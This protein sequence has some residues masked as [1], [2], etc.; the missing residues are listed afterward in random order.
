MKRNINT[1]DRIIRFI[2]TVAFTILMLNDSKDKMIQILAGFLGFYCLATA[3][4]EYCVIYGVLKFST[5]N[6]NRHK[7]LY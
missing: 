7:R 5:R 3:L 4:F 2:L 6:S 1:T